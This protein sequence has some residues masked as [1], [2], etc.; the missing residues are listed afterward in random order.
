[1]ANDV[2]LGNIISNDLARK[3]IYGTYVVGVVI[4][5]AL[6]AWYGLDGGQPEWLSRALNVSAYLGIPIG[7]LA[8]A[9]ANSKP[10]IV[11]AYNLDGN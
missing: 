2:N 8:L 5:G 3:I 11:P 9:N 7:G 10:V 4:L 6:Q 1:M